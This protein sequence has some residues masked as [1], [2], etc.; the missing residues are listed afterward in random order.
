[1][2]SRY[3]QAP[4]PRTPARDGARTLKRFV[5]TRAR[6]FVL[7]MAFLSLPGL[8]AAQVVP[9]IAPAAAP[10]VAD[11]FGRPVAG[12]TMPDGGPVPRAL[13]LAH[14][15]FDA[16]ATDLIAR[17]GLV[18]TDAE[19]AAFTDYLQRFAQQDRVRRT[20][21]LAALD[22]RLASGAIAP[23]E[24]AR[25]VDYRASLRRLA[26]ADHERDAAAV[27]DEQARRAAAAPWIE[28][29]KL[30]RL[31]QARH[32]GAVA[33]TP[34]GPVPLEALAR[35]LRGYH[36]RGAFR[37]DSPE[38]AAAFWTLVEALPASAIATDSADL[39]PFWLQPIPD[40]DC[41][42]TPVGPC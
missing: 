27:P 28:R 16:V 25:A 8:T 22:S 29:W 35:A 34:S 38:D 33:A 26:V 3:L 31:L 18:A 9:S 15:V 36:D 30:Y 17:N 6:M 10:P 32:G 19:I 42:G 21:A 14:L 23:D 2:Y 4:S 41:M 11:I 37:I 7:G 24:V 13:A 39:T 5:V 1:M 12:A 20:R 40:P